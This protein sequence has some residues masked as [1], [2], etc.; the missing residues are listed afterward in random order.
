LIL[1]R[2]ETTV[3]AFNGLGKVMRAH[4]TTVLALHGINSLLTMRHRLL[5]LLLLLL[6]CLAGMRP[7]CWPSMVWAR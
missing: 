4:M 7:L 3:L 5:L 1:R 6:R 2:D